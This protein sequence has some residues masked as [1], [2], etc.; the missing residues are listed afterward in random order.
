MML[1]VRSCTC[2]AP[3]ARPDR[4][5]RPQHGRAAGQPDPQ[6]KG[7]HRRAR[8]LE[9]ANGAGLNGLEFLNID[10]FSAV[11]AMAAE[12]EANGSALLPGESS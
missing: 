7:R 12:A 9:P 10:D 6:Q 2:K 4:A 8:A 1:K 3:T 5:G 11:E